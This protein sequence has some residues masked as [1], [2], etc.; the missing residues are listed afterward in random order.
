[1][2]VL[3]FLIPASLLGLVSADQPILHDTNRLQRLLLALI[4][5]LPRL[6]FAILGVAVL[7]G[8]LGASLHL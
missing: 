6:L 7:L 3:L 2:T 8:L 5:D 4:T 1:M